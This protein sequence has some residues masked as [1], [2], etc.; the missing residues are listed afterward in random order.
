MVLNGHNFTVIG[1]AARG[2]DGIEPGSVTDLFVP[3]MMKA[4]MTPNG[5]G[6]EDLSD[7]RSS[8]FQILGG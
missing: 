6:M 1:V 8:W 3:V 4:W 2:F 7:R 5:V